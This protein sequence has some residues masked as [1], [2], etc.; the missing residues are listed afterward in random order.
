MTGSHSERTL[1][2]EVAEGL[3]DPAGRVAAILAED[4]GIEHEVAPSISE[5][6]PGLER[7]IQVRVPVTALAAAIARLEGSPDIVSAMPEP[8]AEF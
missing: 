4:D 1:A 6:P 5:P 8:D 7:F 2:V 3:A